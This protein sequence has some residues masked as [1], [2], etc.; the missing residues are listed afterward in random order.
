M[1]AS[2]HPEPRDFEPFVL[3][4]TNP[5]PGASLEEYSRSI[6]NS[7]SSLVG[8]KRWSVFEGERSICVSGQ[9]A[10]KTVYLFDVDGRRLLLTSIIFIK[11][12]IGYSI[13]YKN[14]EKNI[15]RDGKDFEY[16]LGNIRFTS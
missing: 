11:D 6:T 3:M 13:M 7:L 5:Y 14:E 2:K 16:I 10:L 15:G 4:A 1:A 8:A 12:R 9:E